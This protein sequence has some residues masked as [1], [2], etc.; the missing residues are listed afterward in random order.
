MTTA[1]L[2]WSEGSDLPSS[3]A[4]QPLSFNCSFLKATFASYFYKS[5]SEQSDKIQLFYLM[6]VRQL[7]V[8]IWVHNIAQIKL[9]FELKYI[10]FYVDFLTIL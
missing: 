8:V 3:M 2:S 1:V 4:P 9:V 6:Q 5:V 10:I 7:P